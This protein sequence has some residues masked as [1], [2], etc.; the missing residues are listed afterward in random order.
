MTRVLIIT[1]DNILTAAKV[2]LTIELGTTVW[3]LEK[4]EHAIT[5]EHEDN[6]K[7]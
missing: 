2:G 1:G 5:L 4:G 7:V 3:M 6:S